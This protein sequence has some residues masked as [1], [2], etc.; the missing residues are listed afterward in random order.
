M[1]TE[2]EWEGQ[3]Q[4]QSRT[5]VSIILNYR[6]M[7]LQCLS[8]CLYTHFHLKI[9]SNFLEKVQ[10][11]MEQILEWTLQL[12]IPFSSGI[13]EV[14]LCGEGLPWDRPDTVTGIGET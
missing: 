14:S 11:L 3:D 12:I 10:N 2:Y 7:L 9:A 13:R 4:F 8:V 5:L 1:K 6:L